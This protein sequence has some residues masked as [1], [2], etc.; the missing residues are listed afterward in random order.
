MADYLLS[1]QFEKHEILTENRMITVRKRETSLEG[2]QESFEDENMAYGLFKEQ[3]DKNVILS[4]KIAITEQDLEEIPFLRQLHETILQ[5]E[6]LLKKSRG[7]D[8]FVIKKA[9]IDMRKDQYIIKQS[10]KQPI[11][12]HKITK[13]Y[14]K[15]GDD[16]INT[17]LTSLLDPKIVKKILTLYHDIQ[18]SGE[19]E[20]KM[21][22]DE[23]VNKALSNDPLRKRLY[24]LRIQGYPDKEISS[25]LQDEFG[26]TFSVGYISHVFNVQI[27]KRITKQAEEDYLLWFYKKNNLPM[28]R[29]NKCGELLPE[30]NVFFSC[31]KR[32]GKIAFLST[33]KS[34]RNKYKK[35]G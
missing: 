2:I 28:R 18:N 32:K 7:K 31:T 26:R 24:E 25:K 30:H 5:W 1:D 3:G 14:I 19:P 33:C 35:R 16:I 21:T 17:Y 12:A 13:T 6:Q 29:C 11:S 15:S 22:F 34:C 10:Y 8:A 20:F 4:P 27:V 23:I 9:I